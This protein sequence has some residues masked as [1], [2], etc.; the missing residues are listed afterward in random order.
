M[1]YTMYDMINLFA[2]FAEI[3]NIIMMIFILK[4]IQD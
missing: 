3:Q 1:N 2:E 4:M